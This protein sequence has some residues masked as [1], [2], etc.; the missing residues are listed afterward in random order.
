M[1]MPS[2][3]PLPQQKFPG[4]IVPRVEVISIQPARVSA[5]PLVQ[6]YP[7]ASSESFVESSSLPF[8]AYLHLLPPK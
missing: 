8:A 1:K 7:G 5:R 6:E 2:A 3:Y 4:Q